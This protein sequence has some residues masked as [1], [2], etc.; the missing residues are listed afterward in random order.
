VLGEEHLRRTAFPNVAVDLHHRV[1]QPGTPAPL[2]GEILFEDPAHVDVRGT[3]VPTLNAQNGLLLCT[4]SIAKALYNR[5]PTGAYLCDLYAGL[6]AASPN[7]V[8]RFLTMARRVGL[9][10]HA[11]VALQLLSAVFAIRL[12]PP[13]ARRPL[14]EVSDA[15]LLRMTFLPRDPATVWP[16]RRRMLWALCEQA[17]L[18]YATELVR[19]IQ[20]ETIRHA[21]ERPSAA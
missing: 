9:G 10:G 6:M 12:G 7:A 14:A 8:N 1:H 11:A 16:K 13:G 18:R 21:L 15:D 5:E 4:I 2:D 19:I 20:S 17:P 3:K